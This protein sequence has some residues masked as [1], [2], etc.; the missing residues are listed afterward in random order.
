[1]LK[2]YSDDLLFSDVYYTTRISATLLFVYRTNLHR[3][4]DH[5]LLVTFDAKNPYRPLLSSGGRHQ[6]YCFA[7]RMAFSASF[8]GVVRYGFLYGSRFTLPR[9]EPIVKRRSSLVSE[10]EWHNLLS[11]P[12]TCWEVAKVISCRK[13]CGH[14]VCHLGC[15]H[16]PAFAQPFEFVGFSHGTCPS[17][18]AVTSVKPSSSRVSYC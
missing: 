8:S 6:T 4:T 10:T 3:Y 12:K 2:H 17:A 11:L 14:L 16:F 7:W 18:W 9:K 1:M 13:V 15:C 5:P